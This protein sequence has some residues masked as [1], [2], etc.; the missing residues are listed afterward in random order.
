[1]A[2]EELVAGGGNMLMRTAIC[3][4]HESGQAGWVEMEDRANE[5]VLTQ[6]SPQLAIMMGK[7]YGWLCIVIPSLLLSRR[8]RG[9]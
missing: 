2:V 4:Q 3:P 8:M 9:A 7:D 5:N 6:A 1:M